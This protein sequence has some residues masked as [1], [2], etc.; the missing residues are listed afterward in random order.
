MQGL[1]HS[2]TQIIW[3]SCHLC[4]A[5]ITVLWARS[6]WKEIPAHIWTRRKERSMLLLL[7][8]VLLISTVQSIKSWGDKTNL[9]TVSAALYRDNLWQRLQSNFHVTEVWSKAKPTISDSQLIKQWRVWQT[10]LKRHFWTILTCL[11]KIIQKCST[12]LNLSIY[13]KRTPLMNC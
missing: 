6:K 11:S 13:M 7:K 3:I 2:F 4:W 9:S 10:I 5:F 8:S 12:V 1:S